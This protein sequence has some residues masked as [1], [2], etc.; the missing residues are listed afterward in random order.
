MVPLVRLVLLRE[1]LAHVGAFYVDEAG[2]GGD[3]IENRVRHEFALDAQI[4]YFTLTATPF[5]V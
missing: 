1:I 2:A 5:H 4:D 3:P